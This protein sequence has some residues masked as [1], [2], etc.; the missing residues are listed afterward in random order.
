MLIFFCMATKSA[1]NG[2]K[3]TVVICISPAFHAILKAYCDQ[4]G[5][6]IGAYAERW[7]KD[8]VEKG[9]R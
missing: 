3:R 5:L 7:L 9:K 1:K 6:R 2:A 4:K 8:A